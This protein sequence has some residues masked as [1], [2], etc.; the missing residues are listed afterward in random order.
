MS[1]LFSKFDQMCE[2]HGVYKLHTLG[3]SFFVMGYNGKVAKDRR[4]MEDAI[5]EGYNVLQL[6]LQMQEI[7]IDER[8]RA[9][10]P[11]LKDLDLKVGIHTGRILG[12]IIG[13][14]IVRYDVFGPD[15]MAVKKIEHSCTVGSLFVS[16]QF[17]NLIKRKQFVWDTFD[18]TEV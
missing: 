7:V 6:A 14:K 2:Q 12:G 15:V 16:E 4:T 17:H 1:R 3:D 11:Y 5:N 8:K 9:N 10:S 18:W 13:S